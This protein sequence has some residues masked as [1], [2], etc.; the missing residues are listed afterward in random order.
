MRPRGLKKALEGIS[1]PSSHFSDLH[2]ISRSSIYRSTQSLEPPVISCPA[3]S[4]AMNKVMSST[5]WHIST[6]YTDF[7]SSI[8]G[9][10]CHW[11][12]VYLYASSQSTLS[13]PSSVCI[14][15]R[16]AP[17]DRVLE[18]NHD[19]YHFRLFEGFIIA[20]CRVYLEELT[21]ISPTCRFSGLIPEQG[22]IFMKGKRFL[23]SI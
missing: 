5:S 15:A 18:P 12:Y 14:K 4:S 8:K 19:Q 2:Q 3:F 13:K 6:L 21:E 10:K 22:K 23:L 17:F 9:L 16:P 11:E 20:A 7:A 1:I